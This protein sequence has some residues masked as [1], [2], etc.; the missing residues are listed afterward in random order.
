MLVVVLTFLHQRRYL[1]GKLSGVVGPG[2]AE[3][4]EYPARFVVELTW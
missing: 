2:I 4:G 1:E 3:I